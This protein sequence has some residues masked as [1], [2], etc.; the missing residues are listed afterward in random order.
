M[1]SR[2]SKQIRKRAVGTFLFLLG[3]SLWAITAT[4]PVTL[5]NPQLVS[6][7]H[8]EQLSLWVVVGGAFVAAGI[9]LLANS[10]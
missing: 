5:S 2:R 1:T 9:I 6:L 3:I 4:L 8:I 10:D 7:G